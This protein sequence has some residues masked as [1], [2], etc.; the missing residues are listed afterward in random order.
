MSAA[1]MLGALPPHPESTHPRVK[2]GNHLTASA[3]PPT[4]AVVDYASRVRLWPM[5]MNDRLGD[6]TCAGIGHSVQAWTAYA[7]GLVTLP[8]SA[9]LNLYERMGYVPGDASTDNGAVE[10]DVLAE[11]HKNGIGGHKILAYAQ[12]DHKDPDEMKTALNLF[13]TVYLGAQMPQ[14]AMDQTNAGQPW[15]AVAGSP[16]E[17]GHCFV[18]QRWDTSAAP[19]EV[20]TWGQLQ[21]VTMDWWM[22]NGLEAWVVISQDWLNA[23]GKTVTGLDLVQLGGD[24]SVISGQPNPFRAPAKSRKFFCTG[25]RDRLRFW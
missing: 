22:A 8:N 6:C 9:V 12:V 18:A 5:Y 1:G 2:L 4:P 3:L 20:V 11:V 7:K 19:M 13:G 21:R 14:S 15:S 25:L 23:A 24:F 17:G 10:Q 16:I